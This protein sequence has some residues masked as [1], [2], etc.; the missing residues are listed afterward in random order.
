MVCGMYVCMC[1]CAYVCLSQTGRASACICLAQK[2]GLAA[3]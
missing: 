2:G 1:V 3:R